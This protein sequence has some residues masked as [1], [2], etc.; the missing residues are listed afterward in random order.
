MSA[1]LILVVGPSGAGKDALIEAGRRARPGLFYP[2]RV[3]T[4]PADAAGEEHEGVDPAAF[5]RMEA[6]GRFA[7][8]W[9][10]H[11]LAYGVPRAI[12]DELAAGRDAVVNVSRSAVEAARALWPA[13]RVILVEAARE[14]RAARLRARGREDAGEIDSRL[15]R[16]PAV[17]TAGADVLVV[18]NSG[19]FE[20]AVS[21]FL[22]ALDRQPERG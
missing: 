15:A 14:T 4:R 16:E 9:R 22:A 10:A 5:E 21:A 11:G 13:V 8:T 2:K 17:M 20:D 19:R 12:L 18:D 3:V 6:E 1:T 7:L